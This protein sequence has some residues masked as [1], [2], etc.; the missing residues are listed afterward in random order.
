M[1]Q[2]SDTVTSFYLNY[3][4]REQNSMTISTKDI[5]PVRLVLA[6]YRCFA[7]II[8]IEIGPHIAKFWNFYY[9]ERV[10]A[11]PQQETPKTFSFSG[12]LCRR[13][14]REDSLTR[15]QKTAGVYKITLWRIIILTKT[16]QILGEKSLWVYF[17]K[18]LL[19]R[20]HFRKNSPFQ[21]IL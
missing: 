14:W 15:L 7:R 3:I 19:L 9:P 21:P 2:W 1:V 11:T 5:N 18:K 10:R 20:A 8:L 17:R 6:K 13:L 12:C 16:P 4:K